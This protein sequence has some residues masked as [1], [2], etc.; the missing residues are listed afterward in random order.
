MAGAGLDDAERIGGDLGVCSVPQPAVLRRRRTGGRARRPPRTCRRSSRPRA[1]GGARA[2]GRACRACRSSREAGPARRGELELDEDVVG[3][4]DLDRPAFNGPPRRGASAARSS[5]S[6]GR[7]DTAEYRRHLV[8]PVDPVV[9]D[10]AD[11]LAVERRRVA[12]VLAPGGRTGVGVMSDGERRGPSR[13]DSAS[14]FSHRISAP[15]TPARPGT[16]RRA[17][18]ARSMSASASVRLDAIGFS[19]KQATPASRIARLTVPW[20]GAGVRL[21]TPSRDSAPS[22]SRALRWAAVRGD[23]PAAADATR[24]AAAGLGSATAED[25]RGIDRDSRPGR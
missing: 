20:S 1:R 14:S 7:A 25:Y 23:Q 3:R 10:R 21:K 6:P 13:P 2:T 12:G 18:P 11:A 24:S 8:Q 22:I 5:P 16:A 17:E 19:L 15:R 4:R 9:E